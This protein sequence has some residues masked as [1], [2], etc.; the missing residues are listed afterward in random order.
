MFV[1]YFRIL[2]F[3]IV[4]ERL[5]FAFVFGLAIIK[6]IKAIYLGQFVF[7]LYFHQGNQGY[8]FG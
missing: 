8:L 3:A 5:P 4:W 6:V 7:A 2:I 1:N